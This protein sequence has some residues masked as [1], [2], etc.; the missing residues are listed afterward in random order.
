MNDLIRPSL[1]K[2]HHEIVP[3]V[4]DQRPEIVADIVGPVC[5]TGDF[6]ARGRKNGRC[7]AGRG[8][9]GVHRRSVR[10]CPF[11]ELQCA[12]ATA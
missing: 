5:E 6:L 11:L 8:V 1:Y 3:L 7:E 4:R 10:V 9:G 12:T 2:S